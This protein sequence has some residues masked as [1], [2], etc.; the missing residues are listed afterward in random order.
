MTLDGVHLATVGAGETVGE[1][2]LLDGGR[3]SA[4]V[5]TTTPTVVLVIEGLR[6][7]A[8]VNAVPAV[9]QAVVRA[10][11]GRLREQDETNAGPRAAAI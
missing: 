1:M 7:E 5:T 8:L 11:S 9:S 6:F 3:R 2:A 10:L 4:T